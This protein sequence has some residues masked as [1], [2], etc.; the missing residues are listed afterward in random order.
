MPGTE[1]TMVNNSDMLTHDVT[2]QWQKQVYH[3]T[4][5]IKRRKYKLISGRKVREKLP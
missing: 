4:G 2:V 3:C 1:G 5:D